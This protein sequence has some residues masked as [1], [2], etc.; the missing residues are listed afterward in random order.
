MSVDQAPLEGRVAV[1]TGANHGIGAAIARA[2]AGRGAD[3]VVTYLRV[4]GVTPGADRSADYLAAREQ[5]AAA[6][7]REIEARGRRCVTVEADL[8][9]S[10]APARTRL[11]RGAC[12]RRS[13]RCGPR[14]VSSVGRG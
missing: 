14:S 7:E 5:S 1:V 6:I 4:L 8:C 12:R 13:R 11:R 10:A 2:L 9:E 3:V